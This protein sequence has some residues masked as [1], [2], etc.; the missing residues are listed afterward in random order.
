MKM[1]LHT[2]GF[3]MTPAIAAHTNK[4]LARGLAN[5][6][7]HV[8]AVEVQLSDINGPKGGCDKKA[9]IC[10]RL[11]SRLTI[12]VERTHA[13]LYVAISAVVG[14]LRRAVRR[15]LRKHKRMEKSLLREMRQFPRVL[16]AN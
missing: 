2:Q 3:E 1:H 16:P 6:E 12:K 4:Q 9:L 7:D 5:F 8:T 11:A 15:V 10:V 14:K 13:D